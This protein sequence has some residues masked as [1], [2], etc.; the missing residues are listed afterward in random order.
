MTTTIN[1]SLPKE[2][3][4]DAKRV[5]RERRYASISELVR[6]GMRKI[7]YDEDEVWETEEDVKRYFRNLREE[8]KGRNGKGQKIG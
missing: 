8:I 1:I 6:E 3:Y 7:I 5:I 4:K 2:M